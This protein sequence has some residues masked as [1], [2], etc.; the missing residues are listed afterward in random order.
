V[1]FP[2]A[3][4]L[5]RYDRTLLIVSD[6]DFHHYHTNLHTLFTIVSVYS[7]DSCHHT[8]HVY[9]VIDITVVLGNNLSYYLIYDSLKFSI[10]SLSSFS[11]TVWLIIY[12]RH[13]SH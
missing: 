2:T 3:F 13:F 1:F 4:Y 6:G 5:G 11:P 10:S 12:C 8:F 7:E 9:L